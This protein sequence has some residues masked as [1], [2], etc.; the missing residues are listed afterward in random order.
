MGKKNIP[1][2]RHHR[3][4]NSLFPLFHGKLSLNL[5]HDLPQTRRSIHFR[6]I[7]CK[8]Y[9][10]LCMYSS[11]GP[12][13][14]EF[15]SRVTC[16]ITCLPPRSQ[17]RT[18]GLQLP[19]LHVADENIL[20]I[21]FSPDVKRGS[22]QH[23]VSRFQLQTHFINLMEIRIGLSNCVCLGKITIDNGWI[24]DKI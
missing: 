13:L 21:I 1:N 23:S 4:R 3:V 9:W 10:Y 16:V 15:P 14:Q 2:G 17:W 5:P 22:K 20:N 8:T 12:V 24:A 19:P 7:F 18:D 11:G 6:D